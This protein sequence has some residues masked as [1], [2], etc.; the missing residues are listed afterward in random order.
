MFSISTPICSSPRPA[1]SK[2]SP[3]GVS[4]TLIATLDLGLAHQPLADHPALH[5][6]AVAAGER[7]VVDAEGDGMVGGSIGCAGSGATTDGSAMVSATVALVMP[8]RLTMSPASALSTGRAREAAEGQH[9]GD[10][11]P[12]DLVAVAGER[13][14]RLAGPHRALLDPPGQQP[15]EERVG[16]Q[17]RRQHREGLVAPRRLRR[18]RNVVD[19]HPV[20]RVEVPARPVERGVRPAAASGG[21][22][23][24]EVELRLVGV[25]RHEEVEDL[26]QRPVG[27]GVGPVDLVQQHDRPEAQPQRLGQHE[28][29]L[30]HRPFGG[31]DQQEHA[32]HHAE[33]ALDLAAE[34]GVAGG[35]DDVD[36]VAAA[37]R[38]RSPWRGW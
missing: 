20:E 29:G 33:D 38:P 7:A 1:T 37:I 8:A 24:R 31:V 2:A 34:V 36:A 22:E 5:L 10:A 25:Q 11:E 27:L 12:L 32:V 3:C 13:A 21:V 18:R 14:D 15:P 35:V 9:L 6:V 19:D 28:L 30:R 26:V 17:R 23:H 16:G 4:L